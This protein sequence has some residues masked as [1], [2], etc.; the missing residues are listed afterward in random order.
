MPSS[1][2]KDDV[3]ISKSTKPGKK[4]KAVFSDGSVLHFGST[5]YQQFKDSTGLG[6]YS[7]KDHG[8][9]KR[10]ANFHARHDFAR[11]PKKSAGYLSFGGRF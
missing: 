1:I 2:K 9:L 6:A 8:D 7:R 11:K 4:Y 5:A 3:V 10:R